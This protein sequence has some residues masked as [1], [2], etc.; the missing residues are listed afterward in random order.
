[1][2]KSIVK[3]YAG[4]KL[5]SVKEKEEIAQG[6]TDKIIMSP[7]SQ[8]GAPFAVKEGHFLKWNLDLDPDD[9]LITD[10]EQQTQIRLEQTFIIEGETETGKFA[11][12]Y[13]Y[14]DKGDE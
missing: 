12:V 6:L 5:I 8:P 11:A 13:L 9:P 3:Y 2:D 10:M 1:M 7:K 4:G 14:L